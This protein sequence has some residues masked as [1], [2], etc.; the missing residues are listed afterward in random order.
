MVLPYGEARVAGTNDEGTLAGG[1]ERA[2]VA[3]ASVHSA[4]ICGGRA[5]AV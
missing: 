1:E 4:Y 5:M 2:G 3:Q